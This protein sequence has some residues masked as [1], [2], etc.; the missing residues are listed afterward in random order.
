MEV[1]LLEKVVNLGSMGDKVSVKAGFARNFLIPQGAAKLATK[2][3]LAEFEVKRAELE[4]ANAEKMKVAQERAEKLQTLSA[5]IYAKVGEEGKLFGSI[6]TRDIA[7]ALNAAGA[8]ITK[9]EVRLP[10]TGA[11]REV[12]EYMIGLHIHADVDVEVKINVLPQLS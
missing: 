9:S 6:G 8:E 7:E 3:N 1:I 11:I 2:Q 4:A 10:D 5:T 12:G